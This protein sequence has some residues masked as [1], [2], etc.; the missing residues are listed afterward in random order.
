MRLL[1]KILTGRYWIVYY[2]TYLVSFGLLTWYFRAKLQ[3]PGGE[4]DV[5]QLFITAALFAVAAGFATLVAIF[6]EVTGR[7]VLLIPAAW[8]KA[9]AEGHAEGVAEGHEM[10]LAEG[11]ETGLAEGRETG[12]AEGRENE[13]N[14]VRS[15]LT[16]QGQRDPTTGAITLSPEA[17]ARLLNGAGEP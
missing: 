7:M 16:E 9:K 4:P 14:R 6:F 13:H 11:H 1:D 8:R 15:I 10:G 3:W 17:A 12:L 5:E 2:L